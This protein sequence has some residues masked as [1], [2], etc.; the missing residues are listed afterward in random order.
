MYTKTTLVNTHFILEKVGFTRALDIVHY[1]C[2]EIL[3]V[4]SSKDCLTKPNDH[5]QSKAIVYN[6]KTTT[7]FHGKIVILTVENVIFYCAG[8]LT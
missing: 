8:M 7:D 2:S 4:C 6:E 3:D 1:F 5:Q